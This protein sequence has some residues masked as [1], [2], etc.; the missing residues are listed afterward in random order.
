MWLLAL[1]ISAILFWRARETFV[2]QPSEVKREI[3]TKITL[4]WRINYSLWQYIRYF[5]AYITQWAHQWA[6][7][8][9]RRIQAW[10]PKDA[11]FYLNH[12]C[13]LRQARTPRKW[14]DLIWNRRGFDDI[15]LHAQHLYAGTTVK[16]PIARSNICLCR[17]GFASAC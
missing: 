3:I 5:N 8:V 7:F 12:C 1:Y 14:S 9:L 17:C 16:I 6:H 11:F 13:H 2:K 15:L 10:F 4:E